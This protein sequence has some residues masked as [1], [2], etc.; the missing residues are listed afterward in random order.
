V[1]RG[2]NTLSVDIKGRVAVPSRYR[3]RLVSIAD[4]NLVL[5][6]NPLDRSLWLYPLPEWEVIEAKLATLSDFD[7]KSRRTKQMMHGYAIDCQMDGQG[8]ILVPI[9]LREYAG[10]EKQ[11]AI[12]GQGN[13]FE[14]WDEETWNQ[15]RDE[16]LEA[17]GNDSETS[18]DSLKSLSL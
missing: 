11:A 3:D 15:Q 4:G 6:L 9:E 5:T 13:K 14:I 8:R 16:W 18:S 7:T 12:L 1:F 10:L 2:F 17:V